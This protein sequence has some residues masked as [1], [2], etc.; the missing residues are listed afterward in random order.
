MVKQFDQFGKRD[1]PAMVSAIDSVGEKRGGKPGFSGAGW[2]HEDQVTAFFHVIKPVVHVH[3]FF[4]FGF[5]CR[6]NG[7][8]SIAYFSG[9]LARVSRIFLA[10]SF[11]S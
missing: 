1:I 5:G 10:F 8:V 7:K 6:L 4:F 9:I 2:T 11:L 3:D